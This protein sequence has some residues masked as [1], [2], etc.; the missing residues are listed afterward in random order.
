M[1]IKNRSQLATAKL[2]KKHYMRSFKTRATQKNKSAI[3]NLVYRNFPMADL[4]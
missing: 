2:Q 3:R 4:S 1:R